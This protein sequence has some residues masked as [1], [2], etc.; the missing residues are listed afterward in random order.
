MKQ[1]TVVDSPYGPLTL[2]AD[3]G[4]LC[5]L[6]MTE[7]RHRPPEESFGPR[8]DTLFAATEEQLEAYFSGELKEFTLELRLHGTP[9]QQTVWN[10]LK[11]IPYGETR[12]YG[13]LAEALGNPAASRAVGLA[14]G[15]NPVGIVVPCHRVVG[16]NGSLTGYGGGL[17]RK[18]RLLDFE[19]GTALFQPLF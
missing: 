15:R 13:E 17:D 11:R 19:S 18:Q 5:G 7:Q 6:Y 3:D 9:F 10:E 4:V 16:A 8:D 14:N 1:H 12:S 2:V